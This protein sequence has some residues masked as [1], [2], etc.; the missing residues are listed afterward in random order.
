MNK[1]NSALKLWDALIKGIVLI[2][3][4]VYIGGCIYLYAQGTEVNLPDWVVSI[5]TI[6]FMYFFRRGMKD[7][8][9][10]VTNGTK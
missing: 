1:I 7:P 4:T 9:K 6:V 8:D 10:E 2:V 5:M 3:L